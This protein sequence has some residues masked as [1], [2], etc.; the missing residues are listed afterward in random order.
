[1]GE[2]V[3]TEHFSVE[4]TNKQSALLEEA[5]RQ[6]FPELILDTRMLVHGKI[7]ARTIFIPKNTVL[8]GVETNKDNICVLFGDISVFTETGTKRLTGFHVLPAFA[9]F[10][11]SGYAHADTWWTTLHH[12]ILTDEVKIEEE[13]TNDAAS[14]Q[15]RRMRLAQDSIKLVEGD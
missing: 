14:L 4:H 12:T 10:K 13:M 5:I 2:V 6:N 9:G 11:R 7:C 1:M 3:N 8:V 15:T